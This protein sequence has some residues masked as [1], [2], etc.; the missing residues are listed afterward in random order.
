[1]VLHS[2]MI[3]TSKRNLMEP[4]AIRTSRINRTTATETKITKIVTNIMVMEAAMRLSR[5]TLTVITRGITTTKATSKRVTKVIK[6]TIIRTVVRL[7]N[8]SIQR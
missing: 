1:M 7:T 6:T 4:R 5:M 3:K 2:L 8:F